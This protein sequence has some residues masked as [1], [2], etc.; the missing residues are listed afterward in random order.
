MWRRSEQDLQ[1]RYTCVI[2][3]G[4]VK[5]HNAL[6]EDDPYNGVPIVNHDCVGHVQKRMGSR[7]CKRR[8][9]GCYS[10]AKK[11]MVPLGEKGRI[12]E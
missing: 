11:K 6:V 9:E 12:T 5:T 2:A 7:L 10:A 1:L 3:D 4:D 8:K